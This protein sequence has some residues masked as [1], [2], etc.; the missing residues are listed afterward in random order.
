MALNSTVSRLN[1]NLE[2]LVFTEGGKLEYLEKNLGAGTRTNKL[3]PHMMPRPEIEPRPHWWE[4][5][6]LT[7]VPSLPPIIIL[8]LAIIII[9]CH[10]YTCSADSE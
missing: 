4:A 3:S 6:A 10:L 1:W 8:I 2:M 5:S 9:N 7:T